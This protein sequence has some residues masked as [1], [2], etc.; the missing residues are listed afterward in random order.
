MSNSYP[1]ET[2]RLLMTS[3]IAEAM[4]NSI[5]FS[6]F[7]SGS[8]SRYVN[9]DWGNTHPDDCK[10]NRQAIRHGDRIFAVYINPDEPHETIWIITESDRKHTT[11]LFPEEY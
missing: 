7:V 1:F 10:L 2:G 6:K 5:A 9:A 11:V 8:I 4:Q 3:G